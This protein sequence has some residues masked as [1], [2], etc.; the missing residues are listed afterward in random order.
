MWEEPGLRI[1][2]SGFRFGPGVSLSG[3]ACAGGDRLDE[4]HGIIL[5]L[6]SRRVFLQRANVNMESLFVP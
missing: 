3:G 4:L 5:L 6:R 1:S 2:D